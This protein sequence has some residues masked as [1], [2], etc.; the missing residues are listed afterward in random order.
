[1]FEIILVCLDGSNLSEQI[2]PYAEQQALRFG[3]EVH[4]LHVVEKPATIAAPGKPEPVPEKQECFGPENLEAPAYLQAMTSSLLSNGLKVQC[5]VVEGK[6]GEA[7]ITYAEQY[8][9][10]LIAM[11]THGRGGLGR[12]VLGSVAD[13]VLRE[14]GLPILLIRPQE[15]VT[16]QQVDS[17]S[18]EK[19]LVCLDGSK[20]AEQIMPYATEEALRFQ[21]TLILFQ[22]VREP[23]TISPGIPGEASM[24]VETETMLEETQKALNEANNYLE[25]LAV[26][27]REKSIQVETV[28]IP[29]RAGEAIVSYAN[30][31]NLNLIAIATH[32]RS[33]LGRAVFGSVADFVLRESGLP[34]LVTK[35]KE[36]S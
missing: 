2:I 9:I 22:V 8:G 29:G 33:G 6:V 13:F 23:L 35:P 15:M 27:L 3:S 34:I 32:G 30:R 11:A 4:L 17:P 31:N 7:I 36:I 10:N 19:I 5:A 16:Q 26:P 12:A 1:M 14:S 28:T 21:S 25:E 20:V 18:F 24:P